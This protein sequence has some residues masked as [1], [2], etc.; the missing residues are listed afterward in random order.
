MV[1]RGAYDEEQEDPQPAKASGTICGA[2]GELTA[3]GDCVCDGG[4]YEDC[5]ICHVK[6]R[7]GDEIAEM[8]DPLTYDLAVASEYGEQAAYDGCTSGVVH[9]ECGFQANW[10]MA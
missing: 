9:G 4:P 7:K 8:F 5:A 2:C 1:D 6:F 10:Q 3:L